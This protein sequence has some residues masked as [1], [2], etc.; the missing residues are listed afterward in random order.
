MIS[1]V[2]I[3]KVGQWIAALPVGRQNA[4][5]RFRHII[6]EALPEITEVFKWNLPVY[7]HVKNLVYLNDT[8]EGLVVGFMNGAQMEDPANI[9]GA[10]DR[11]LVRHL[12]FPSEKEGPWED[13]AFYLQESAILNES[14]QKNSRNKINP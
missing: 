10:K 8:R 3:P 2:P 12:L 6:F 13:L 5:E 1:P 4:A 9:F 7:A 11:S 14:N